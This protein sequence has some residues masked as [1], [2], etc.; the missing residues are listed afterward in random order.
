MK[1]RVKIQ[2]C[3]CERRC[4]KD[5]LLFNSPKLTADSNRSRRTRMKI[6]RYFVSAWEMKGFVYFDA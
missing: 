2:A 4:E 6:K 1:E 3:V 5:I